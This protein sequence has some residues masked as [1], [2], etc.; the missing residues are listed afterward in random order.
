MLLE[1]CREYEVPVIMGSDSHA[2]FQIGV[3]DDAINLIEEIDFPRELIV[4]DSVEKFK[5]YLASG[6]ELGKN[7]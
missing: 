1:K 2:D 6:R 3:F 7:L 4:N 5:Y